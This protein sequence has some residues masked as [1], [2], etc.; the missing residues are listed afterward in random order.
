MGMSGPPL[1]TIRFGL[2]ELDLEAGELRKNGAKLKLQDQPFQVLLALLENP[3]QVVT[4]ET[5]RKRVWL[6]H[7]F[8]DFDQGL[9]TAI[10]KIREV[11]GDS[12]SNPRFVETVPRRGYR[13]IAPVE[14]PEPGPAPQ[15]RRSILSV[16]LA[17]G[18]S[19][20]AFGFAIGWWFTVSSGG[21]SQFPA[22]YRLDRLTSDIGLTYQPAL[23]PDGRLVAYASDRAGKDNLDIWIKTVAGGEPR[24]L[25]TH[26]AGDREPAFSLDGS[27]IAFRSDRDGGGIYVMSTLGGELQVVAAEGRRPRFS[28]DGQ[29]IAYWVG[30]RQML[31]G[32]VFVVSSSGGAPTRV[33]SILTSAGYPVWSPDGEQLLVLAKEE[34]ANALD[35][36]IIP[37]DAGDP[38]KTNVM[39][40][41]RKYGIDGG[42]IFRPHIPPEAWRPEDNSV[43][44][45][46]QLGGS[47]N[48]WSIQLSPDNWQT[49]GDPERITFGSGLETH[50]SRSGGGHIAFASMVQNTDVFALPVEANTGKVTG[51][52]Q[53]L[54][55]DA[56]DDVTPTIS[57]DGKTVAFLSKRLGNRDV[58]VKDLRSGM[59]KAL[60]VTPQNERFP[61]ISQD[62]SKVVYSEDKDQHHG[63][64]YLKQVSGG[65]PQEI[66]GDC[67]VPLSWSWDGSRLLHRI[68]PRSGIGLFDL[69]SQE[70]LE[71]LRH[72]EHQVFGFQLSPDGKWIAFHLNLERHT[73]VFVI[74][75]GGRLPLEPGDRMAITDASSEHRH[76]RWSP[77]GNLLYY[78][79]DRDGFPC[80]WAQRLHPQT[81]E[82]MGEP[83]EVYPSHNARLSLWN[84]TNPAYIWVGVA[85][86]KLVFTMG[87]ITGNIWMMELTEQ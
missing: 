68:G 15:P 67:G 19:A 80:I 84:C 81:K 73:Q 59:E 50:A 78:Q 23:S 2:Y 41:V 49:R 32:Q 25:T 86:D 62:G 71:V 27:R 30:E 7:T 28:P 31:D 76:P 51:S 42:L 74:P 13:F 75:F 58:W 1:G 22:D 24:Q 8:V 46:G 79:S 33:G 29:W 40:S 48:L 82:P 21:G 77:D 20:L 52:L 17:V 16:A 55:R 70:N 18:V 11:L 47:T 38:I 66:C 12:A 6:G 45:S 34:S 83:F 39:G 69:V 61:M 60:T 54:T 26:P 4:R 57:L 87:E 44:F 36:W 43:V 9:N 63:R 37:L 56:A 72:P 14:L 3:D 65:L 64:L 10:A 53:R 85:R 5:L 35:W